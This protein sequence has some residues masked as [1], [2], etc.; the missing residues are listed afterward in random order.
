[1]GA[2]Y[3]RLATNGRGQPEEVV[4]PQRDPGGM[5]WFVLLGWKEGGEGRSPHLLMALCVV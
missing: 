2:C 3:G 4:R 5:F 1:M